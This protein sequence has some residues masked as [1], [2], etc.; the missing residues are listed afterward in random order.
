MNLQLFSLRKLSFDE[1]LEYTQNLRLENK[2][3]KRKLKEILVLCSNIE[4]FGKKIK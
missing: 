1:L 2:I 4:D 3:L